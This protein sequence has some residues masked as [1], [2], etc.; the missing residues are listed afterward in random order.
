MCPL[1]KDRQCKV[2]EQPSGK[3]VCEC[4]RHS[5]PNS[6]IYAESCRLASLTIIR[7]VHTWTQAF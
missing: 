4:S 6:A 5:W 2:L 3:L 1:C 7:T